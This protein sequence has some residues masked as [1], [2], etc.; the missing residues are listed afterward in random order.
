MRCCSEN[1]SAD[2]FRVNS[3]G[4]AVSTFETT[5][6]KLSEVY[7]NASETVREILREASEA[8]RV[9]FITRLGNFYEV[10]SDTV[11]GV[12]LCIDSSSLLEVAADNEKR[13]AVYE[14]YPLWSEIS[15]DTDI[16][17][18]LLLYRQEVI[19]QIQRLF[20]DKLRNMITDRFTKLYEETTR[21]DTETRRN[22]FA[23][24]I[25]DFCESIL[26]RPCL[27]MSYD[28]ETARKLIE[29]IESER[30][31]NGDILDNVDGVVRESLGRL[32]SLD[33]RLGYGSIC[34]Q[35]DT[36]YMQLVGLFEKLR[37]FRISKY[38]AL[39]AIDGLLR[40]N[41]IVGC[42]VLYD[43]RNNYSDDDMQS[44]TEVY[45]LLMSKLDVF[46]MELSR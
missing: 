30:L 24:M 31:Y 6:E 13:R 19:E 42:I 44:F 25:R 45:R 12:D 28:K 23:K 26:V 46:S 18:F 20:R 3:V 21:Y 32:G 7:S 4:V 33:K 40:L 17:T 15:D 38:A 34:I 16:R 9:I 29:M 10:D 11:R 39:D 37:E 27:Y 14:L 36:I 43:L 8:I 22:D 41:D 35:T 2:S 1:V 5:L